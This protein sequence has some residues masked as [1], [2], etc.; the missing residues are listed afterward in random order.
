[1]NFLKQK[2]NPFVLDF[3]LVGTKEDYFQSRSNIDHGTTDSDTNT[4]A[5]TTTTNN[6][7]DKRKGNQAISSSTENS[8]SRHCQSIGSAIIAGQS[9]ENAGRRRLNIHESDDLSDEESDELLDLIIE[10]LSEN[11][12]ENDE[13]SNE[14]RIPTANR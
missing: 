12:T 11:E 7:T 8:H 1:M 13:S 2:I 5:T 4:T 14:Q 10:P 6:V 3:Q 9:T